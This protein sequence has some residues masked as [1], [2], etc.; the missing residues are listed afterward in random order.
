MPLLSGVLQGSVLG[1]L[2]F[3][4]INSIP[5]SSDTQTVLYADDLLFHPISLQQDFTTLQWDI[6]QWV[7]NNQLTFNTTIVEYPGVLLSFHL[8][9]TPHITPVCFKAKQILGLLY[10][11][12]L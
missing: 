5:T 7:F 1:P 10:R 11:R 4:G 9:W 3:N 8:S 2:L 6:I 12:F